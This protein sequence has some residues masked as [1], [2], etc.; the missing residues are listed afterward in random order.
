VTGPEQWELQG[1][2]P[3]CG[4]ADFFFLFPLDGL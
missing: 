3:G 2:L 4:E 1:E